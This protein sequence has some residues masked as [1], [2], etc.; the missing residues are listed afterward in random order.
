MTLEDETHANDATMG[1][2]DVEIL[3]VEINFDG[4]APG[5]QQQSPEASADEDISPLDYARYHALCK[6]YLSDPPL[7]AAQLPTPPADIL[8]DFEDPEHT[9]AFKLPQELSEREPVTLNME[10]AAFLR[11]VLT[12]PD[13]PMDSED[14]VLRPKITDLKQ[15]LPVLRIDDEW[16]L[17]QFGRTQVVDLARITLPMVEIGEERDEGLSWPKRYLDLPAQF[18]TH[19]AAER[20]EVPADTLPFLQEALSDSYTPADKL[21]ITSQAFKCQRVSQA[22]LELVEPR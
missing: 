13:T 21:N 5:E 2:D 10:A 15:E 22:S 14:G 6:D 3:H 7:E 9:Q 1:D 17:R 19:A 11:D 4:A 18:D 20:L 16:D 8:K 12:A